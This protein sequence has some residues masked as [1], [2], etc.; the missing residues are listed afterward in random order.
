[1]R[2]LLSILIIG[3]TSILLLSCASVPDE[4]QVVVSRINED[5]YKQIIDNNS[6]GQ[7]EYNAFYNNFEFRGT[8]LNN[9]VNEAMLTREGDYYQWEDAKSVTE[10][11]KLT[12]ETSSMTRVHISF[13]T[14]EHKNDNLT[15][16]KSI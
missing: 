8:L 7:S 9:A 12:Q 11:E 6:D 10:K 3:L 16:T 5:S 13:F 14:P 4:P 1:M 2:N 15:D